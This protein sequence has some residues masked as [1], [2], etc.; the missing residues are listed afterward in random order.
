MDGRQ[1]CSVGLG[2]GNAVT[3]KAAHLFREYELERAGEVD[4]EIPCRMAGA[5][6]GLDGT[7]PEA[8]LRLVAPCRGQISAVLAAEAVPERVVVLKSKWR[9]HMDMPLRG[10]LEFRYSRKR[11]VVA[12]S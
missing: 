7:A 6:M 11:R 9:S 3:L 2:P 10:P 4:S 5:A 8:F 12:T 1:S